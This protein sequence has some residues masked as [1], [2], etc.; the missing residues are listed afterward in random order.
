MSSVVALSLLTKYGVREPERAILA[1]FISPHRKSIILQ[2]KTK[3]ENI[4]IATYLP[5]LS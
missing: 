5:N 1:S 4:D 2:K 3:K